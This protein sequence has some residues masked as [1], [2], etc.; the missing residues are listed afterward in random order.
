MENKISAVLN[1]YNAE[2]HLAR[3]LDS[4]Q[5]F[6]EILVCDMESTDSTI[7]IAKSKGCRVVTYPKGNHTIC[8]PARDFAIHEAKY[9]WVLVVDADEIVSEQLCKY[10]YSRI[11]NPHF[12]SALLIA[13][14][15]R[16]M[17]L[18]ATGSPDYQLRFFRKDRATWPAEIH[19]RPLID[20]KVEA[21]PSKRK[22]LYLNHLDDMSVASRL[23]KINRYSDYE[24]SKR[25]NKRYGVAKLLFRPFWFFIR[26]Y[27]FGKGF[28]DGRRGLF[29]AYMSS[30]YQ[31]AYLAKL[32]EKKLGLNYN[33]TT[34][35]R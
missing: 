1:T 25:A 19:A 32:H 33:D 21:I 22:D 13:R 23:D 35:S 20:G 17:G 28:R 31:I 27:L 2:R 16:F 7:R 29:K 8:E 6:D 26:S 3:V 4:L 9:D 10:L 12:G 5:G 18:P 30:V 14:K 34:E 11:A 24:V 15:N